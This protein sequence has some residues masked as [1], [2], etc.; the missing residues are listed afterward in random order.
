MNAIIG[1]VFPIALSIFGGGNVFMFFALM[2]IP[3]F[4]FVLKCLPET[5]G[6]S[7]EE[8]EKIVVA[9]GKMGL[10]R[11]RVYGGQKNI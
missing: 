1:F 10:K 9:E 7:L 4:F 8:L 3:F 6:K 2:M 5:K 11:V